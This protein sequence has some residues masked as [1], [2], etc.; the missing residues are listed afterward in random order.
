M[1]LM[2]EQLPRSANDNVTLTCSFNL[3]GWY[4]GAANLI[5]YSGTEVIYYYDY[6]EN[7]PVCKKSELVSKFPLYHGRI[8]RPVYISYEQFKNTWTGIS[9][10]IYLS[11]FQALTGLR[12]H[13]GFQY[14]QVEWMIDLFSKTCLFVNI[15]IQR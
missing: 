2:Q 3:Y 6:Y 11:R 9:L 13:A 15:F 7:K 1:K 10:F 4:Y 14:N 12:Y 5:L 8:N